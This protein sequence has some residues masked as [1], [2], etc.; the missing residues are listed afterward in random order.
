[1]CLR[2]KTCVSR[3][4]MIALPFLVSEI[5]PFDYYYF[6]FSDYP[7]AHHNSVTVWNIWMKHLSNVYEAKTACRLQKMIDLT[8]F[9]SYFPLI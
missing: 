3:T 5:L 8:F 7:Y 2:S 6:F 9:L 1:M 4:K